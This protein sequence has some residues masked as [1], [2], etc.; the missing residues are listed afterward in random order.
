MYLLFF[1][2]ESVVKF[3][4]KKISENIIYV[5]IK[6][7]LLMYINSIINNITKMNVFRIRHNKFDVRKIL[8]K[9]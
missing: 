8:K 1:C 9:I 6:M 7:R 5:K 2:N 4:L 3:M